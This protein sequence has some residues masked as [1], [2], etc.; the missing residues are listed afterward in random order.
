LQAL[1]AAGAV[2]HTRISSDLQRVRRSLRLNVNECRNT[3]KKWHEFV[4]IGFSLPGGSPDD[5]MRPLSE[6]G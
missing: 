2:N 3:A 6:F 5:R 1:N 4:F